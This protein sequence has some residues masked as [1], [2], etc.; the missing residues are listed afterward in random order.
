MLNLLKNVYIQQIESNFISLKC[1]LFSAGCNANYYN[2]KCGLNRKGNFE[3]CS[4]VDLLMWQT[5]VHVLD[6]LWPP[7]TGLAP[8]WRY[9]IACM[10]VPDGHCGSSRGHLR[11]C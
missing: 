7:Q 1:A 10:Y 8:T 11:P 2:C 4:E 5:R 9:I 3:H 6:G